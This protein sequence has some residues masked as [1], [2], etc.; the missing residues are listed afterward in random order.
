LKDGFGLVG[1]VLL[2]KAAGIIEAGFFMGAI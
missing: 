1:Y 2:R